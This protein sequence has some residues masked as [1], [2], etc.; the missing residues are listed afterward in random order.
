MNKLIL[1]IALLILHSVAAQ[2][3]AIEFNTVEDAIN[4]AIENNHNLSKSRIDQ[5]IILA[6][7]SEVEGRALPQVNVNGK[8][9]DNYSL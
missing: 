3:S 2:D 5:E 6:Q 4:Y 7:I 1:I 9:S 8:Y